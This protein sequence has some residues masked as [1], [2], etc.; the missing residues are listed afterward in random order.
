MECHHATRKKRNKL[1]ILVVG[2]AAALLRENAYLD[3]REHILYL[4]DSSTTGGRYDT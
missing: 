4:V 2:S 1:Q 3:H